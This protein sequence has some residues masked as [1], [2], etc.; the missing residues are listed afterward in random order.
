MIFHFQIKQEVKA[1]KLQTRELVGWE[2]RN[3]KYVTLAAFVHSLF[4][5]K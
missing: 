3:E 4:S 1:K 5:T 2:I